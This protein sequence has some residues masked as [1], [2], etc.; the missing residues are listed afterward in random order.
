MDHKTSHKGPFIK[1]EIYTSSESWIN[2]LSIDVW[3]VSIG[4]YLAE[5]QLFE[6]LESERA[7]KNQNIENI[8]FKVV[9]M[10]LWYIYRN[11]IFT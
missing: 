4:Q 1:I 6:Y 9:Q 2:N 3:F 5:M 7:K 11:M 10:Q 8:S